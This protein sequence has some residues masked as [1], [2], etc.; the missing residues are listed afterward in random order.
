MCTSSIPA[1]TARGPVDVHSWATPAL[2]NCVDDDK[3][4]RMYEQSSYRERTGLT[5]LNTYLCTQPRQV[6]EMDGPSI[7]G[8]LRDRYSRIPVRINVIHETHR[9]G[10]VYPT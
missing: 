3:F 9:P 2:S 1:H 4:E 5:S 8:R 10:N 6:K 7:D